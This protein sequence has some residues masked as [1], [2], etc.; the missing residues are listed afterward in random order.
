MK[1]TTTNAN[2]VS[3]WILNDQLMDPDKH[4]TLQEAVRLTEGRRDL[5]RVVIIESH[6]H[7]SALPYHKKRLA[8][9]IS[10]GRHF[11]EELR[12]K[13]WQ[14]DCISA[15]SFREGLRIH[16]KT[17]SWNQCV[18]MLAAENSTSALQEKLKSTSRDVAFEII[19]NSQFYWPKTEYSKPVKKNVVMENFYRTMRRHYQVLINTDNSP[20]GGQWNYDSDNRKPLPKNHAAPDYPKFKPDEITLNVLKEISP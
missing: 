17:H 19:P 11:A 4:P 2:L 13:G 9:I 16:W 18:T 14:V 7:F 6:R 8:L 12:S 1:P 3:A 10:A 20:V 5:V 15:E